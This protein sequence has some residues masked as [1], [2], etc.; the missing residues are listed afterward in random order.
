MAKLFVPLVLLTGCR[1]FAAYH[2]F[3]QADGVV[4]GEIVDA[5]GLDRG[6]VDVGGVEILGDA[7]IHDEAAPR[8]MVF[9]G[10]LDRALPDTG[11][12][13][14][15]DL[16]GVDPAAVFGT[17]TLVK[18]LST[19]V[20]EDDPTLTGDMLEIYF[21]RGNDI[22][23]SRRASVKVAWDPPQKAMVLSSTAA[24]TNPEMTPD[25]LTIFLASN[26]TDP[27]AQGSYDIYIATRAQ[28]GKPWS[29]PVPVPSLN[30]SGSDHPGPASDLLTMVVI[31]DRTGSLGQHDFYLSTRTTTSSP[32]GTPQAIAAVNTLTQE[33]S[34]WLDASTRLLYY[35]SSRKNANH[36]IWLSIRT[37]SGHS[38]GAPVNVASLNTSASEEDPW[39]SP[40]LRTVYFSSKRNGTIH[41][42][43]ATR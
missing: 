9:D 33:A 39:L 23:S 27:L 18:E 22:W 37:G 16:G 4:D 25:G 38:F 40:D 1:L 20:G 14:A 30:G 10:R 15:S 28:R 43:M 7:G 13:V 24:E 17:P 32:W 42:F 26:R 11:G 34:A 3:V 2:P 8:D 6:I 41:L 19:T 12:D 36:D 31:S 29:T 35:G 5:P 21:N